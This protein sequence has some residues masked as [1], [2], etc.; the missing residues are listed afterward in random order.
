MRG[1]K[2]L[3]GDWQTHLKM[4][5]INSLCSESLRQLQTPPMPKI[6]TKKKKEE[7]GSLGTPNL[8]KRS[9]GTSEKK[10]HSNKRTEHFSKQTES[11]L[12]IDERSETK[13]RCSIERTS[14]FF[15]N[16][17]YDRLWTE[18]LSLAFALPSGRQAWGRFH[19]LLSPGRENGAWGNHRGVFKASHLSAQTDRE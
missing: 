15:Q 3:G 7:K 17:L 13:T 14:L 19:A 5:K 4:W 1:E 18:L 2:K 9:S 8:I 11:D 6:T 12:A 10:V 16:L